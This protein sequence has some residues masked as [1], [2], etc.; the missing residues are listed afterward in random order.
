MD[1]EFKGKFVYLPLDPAN[2][3]KQII[4]N[5]T[6]NQFDLDCSEI[7]ILDSKLAALIE[8]ENEIFN[9]NGDAPQDD[10]VLYDLSEKITE[11][12]QDFKYKQMANFLQNLL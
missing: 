5:G 3:T 2:Q 11:V 9:L 8:Y 12:M 7:V 1:N 4:K 6:H 10:N